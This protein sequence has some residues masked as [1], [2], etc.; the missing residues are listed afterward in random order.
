ME[1]LED[2]P[3]VFLIPLQHYHYQGMDTDLDTNTECLSKKLKMDSR[4]NIQ[5]TGQNMVTLGQLKEWTEYLK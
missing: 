3:H 5:M 2:L 1:D 4:W